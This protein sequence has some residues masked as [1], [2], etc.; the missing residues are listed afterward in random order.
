MTIFVFSRNDK[1]I[2]DFNVDNID[3]LDSALETWAAAEKIQIPRFA[4]AIGAEGRRW[5][6]IENNPLEIVAGVV[7][8]SETQSDVVVNSSRQIEILLK[9]LDAQENQLF[10]IKIIGIPFLVGLIITI[11]YVLKK[12]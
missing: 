1:L 6:V 3:D 12:L 9:I 5:T 10:W 7:N 4:Y 11:L 2:G 8:E